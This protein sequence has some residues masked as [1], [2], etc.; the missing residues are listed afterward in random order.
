MFVVGLAVGYI[1]NVG[2]IFFEG[3][4]PEPQRKAAWF[5][6]LTALG[7][8]AV[9][10]ACTLGLIGRYTPET[11]LENICRLILLESTIS[12]F[13]ASLA[14]N[15]LGARGAV[16]LRQPADDLS[17]D[18]RKIMATILGALLFSYNISPTIEIGLIATGVNG[19]H[20]V[21]LIL[22]S[23]FVSAVMTYF[24]D[25][26]ER[27]ERHGLLSSVGTET[28]VSYGVALGVSVFLLWFFGYVDA[29]TALP[30]LVTNVIVLGYATTL[31]GSAGRLII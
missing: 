24:A 15:Q 10:S 13:G 6:A 28:L 31:G 14:I 19:A 3:Y 9:A 18:L 4:K 26:V 23:L 29:G 16:K 20:L 27:D 12:S 30:D 1:A 25:F 7:I 22:F 17:P 2:Y 21:G 11:P 5:D 8:G